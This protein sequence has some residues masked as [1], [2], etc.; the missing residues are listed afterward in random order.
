MASDTKKHYLVPKHTKLSDAEKGKLLEG[1]SISTKELPKILKSDA[2]IVKLN[3]KESDIIKIERESKTAGKAV[4][5][6]VVVDG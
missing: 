6:R 2:A 4:Y 5:Y 3:A 1:L